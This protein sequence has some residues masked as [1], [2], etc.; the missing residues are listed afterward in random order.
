MTARHPEAQLAQTVVAQKGGFNAALK[1]LEQNPKWPTTKAVIGLIRNLS[2]SP[3]NQIRVRESESLQK[4]TQIL[5]KAAKD[6]TQNYDN[7]RMEEI[8][9]ATLATINN[10]AR[11]PQNRHILR[12]IHKNLF[13]Q[14]N[15]LNTNLSPLIE[16]SI[17]EEFC[18]FSKLRICYSCQT[19]IHLQ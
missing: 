8:I 15:F 7:V 9:E 10:M 1:L 14:V 2:L 6:P 12:Q 5:Q 16:A 3:D 19:V 4:M 11:D 13:H 18:F 17:N